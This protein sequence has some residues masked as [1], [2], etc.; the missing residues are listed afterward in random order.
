MP[1]ST[2][3]RFELT[4]EGMF[5]LVSVQFFNGDRTTPYNHI[6][7]DSGSNM[8]VIP[9][10]IADQLQLVQTPIA[11]T[12]TGGGPVRTYRANVN[13]RLG[14]NDRYVEYTDIEINILDRVG[15]PT[16]IGIRPVWENYIVTINAHE[17]RIIME[18]RQ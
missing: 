13:F 14:S 17:K 4:Y 10:T 3:L 7:L 5:P 6:K 12:Q 16:V 11:D 18:P 8:I 1:H 2:L 15:A 9:K